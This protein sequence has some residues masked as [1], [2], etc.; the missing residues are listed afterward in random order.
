MAR[1]KKHRTSFL[2]PVSEHREATEV[3]EEEGIPLAQL[4]REALRREIDRRRRIR[5]RK[6][7]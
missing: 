3:A 6:S 7:A 2:H 5:A 4:I 1:E